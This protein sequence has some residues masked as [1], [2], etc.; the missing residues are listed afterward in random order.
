MLTF[1]FPLFHL[2]NKMKSSICS[3]LFQI[4]L[5]T[6]HGALH[7][8]D[9]QMLVE[10]LVGW[11]EYLGLVPDEISPSTFSK[12]LFSESDLGAVISFAKTTLPGQLAPCP[13]QNLSG[14]Y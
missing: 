11:M 12:H 6:Q 7:A 10:W 13:V 4:S 1:L 5:S 14:Y 2:M 9:T 8:V 3:V